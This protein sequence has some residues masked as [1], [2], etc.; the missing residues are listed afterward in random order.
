M[1]VIKLLSLLAISFL[2]T[3]CSSK[4]D[5][6]IFEDAKILL[7]EEKYDEACVAFEK[8]AMEQKG[9]EL[10]S[11]AL[12]ESAKLYQGQV[13]TNLGG[14]ESFKKA[15]VLY[16]KIFT[17]Y[18]ESEEAE[19]ALFMAG[20]ILA[21]D[22]SDLD[23]AKKTYELFIEKYPDGDLSD[24]AKVELKNLGKSPEE[25]LMEKIQ[26]ENQNVDAS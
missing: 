3:F 14:K 21:N 19:N 24:D 18:P 15:V 16:K 12:L 25:I 6:E 4:S 11:K 5:K 8:L 2:L 9:S 13:I 20:F 26:Q 22:L 7:T 23:E 17:D 10:A 1:R